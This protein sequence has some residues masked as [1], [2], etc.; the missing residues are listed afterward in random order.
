MINLLIQK[1]SGF[2][3][4]KSLIRKETLKRN[5][6]ILGIILYMGVMIYLCSGS[7]ILYIIE[8]NRSV[9]QIIDQADASMEVFDCLPVQRCTEN[10]SVNSAK[11]C[12]LFGALTAGKRP[13]PVLL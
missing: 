9:E 6:R 8:N 4:K 10:N 12:F 1:I 11:V 3:K 2:L 13:L 5:L 7:T